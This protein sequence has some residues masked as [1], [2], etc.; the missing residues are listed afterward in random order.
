[1][2]ARAAGIAITIGLVAALVAVILLVEGRGHRP[3]VI[4]LSIDTLRYDHL[5]AYGYPRETSPNIDA[6]ARESLVFE[7]AIAHSPSTLSSHASI[8]TSLLPQH[9]GA[10][11]GRETALPEQVLT[12][13]EVLQENRYATASFNGGIQL[14]A[15]YGI[16]QGF[17]LYQSARLENT[18]AH[19][20]RD[21]ED[22]LIS[23]VA[24]ALDWI[25]ATRERPFF[26]FLHSYEVHHPYTPQD[27]FYVPTHEGYEGVVP[28]DVPVEFL[29]AVVAGKVKLNAEDHQRIVD[30]YDAEI[31]SVD[32]AV[33]KLIDELMRT[34]V[35]DETVLIVTSDHGEELGEHGWMGWH[36]HTL[37]DELLRVPLLIRLPEAEDGGRR[38]RHQVRGIDIAPTVLDLVD[39][40][41][42]AV[43][44]G[45][46]LLQA[47]VRD[48]VSHL[49]VSKRDT[50]PEEDILSL[51]TE[52]WKLVHGRVY[53]L[54]EDRAEQTDVYA[55]HRALAESLREA[56]DTLVGERALQAG[57]PVKP[58]SILVDRLRAL[59]YLGEAG[60]RARPA[61]R[62]LTGSYY[63]NAEWQGEPVHRR[64]DPRIDFDWQLPPW[65]LP[66]PFSIEWKGEI[67][68]E[69]AGLYTFHLESDDGSILEIDDRVVVDNGGEH[70]IRT[71]SGTV[72][73]SEGVHDVRIRYFNKFLGGMIRLLWEPAEGPAGAVPVELLMQERPLDVQPAEAASRSIAP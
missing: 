12:L 62:G 70:A 57:T 27:E 61:G 73:L 7:Q 16:A 65:P 71:L 43:F 50:G 44:G 67:R 53:H 17:D 2:K 47:D 40:E 24:R 20:L 1:M 60:S 15:V 26:L 18:P 22:R 8:L 31:R 30:S 11:I 3:N 54:T 59:G 23:V 21:P 52:E 63:P 42:P 10:S 72:R 29:E 13:A 58:D 32:A 6:L 37:Y 64:V 34:G 4:L 66:P 19:A 56:L 33:G 5:G 36:G 45:R 69:R 55:T 46:S 68:I 14:D 25:E 28:R 48:A 9:H 35:L 38:V 39:I 41:V 51:R 49:A